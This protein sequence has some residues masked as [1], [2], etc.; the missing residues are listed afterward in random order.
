[1][2]RRLT[3]GRLSGQLNVFL[4]VLHDI[5]GHFRMDIALW[6]A[7]FFLRRRG[8]PTRHE[9]RSKNSAE[10]GEVRNEGSQR[11]VWISQESTGRARCRNY[12]SSAADLVN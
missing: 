8:A 6:N 4:A 10:R 1:M 7:D 5:R 3:L 2:T 9:G 11:S 12:R